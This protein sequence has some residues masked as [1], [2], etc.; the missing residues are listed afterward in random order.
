M[1]NAT[2]PRGGSDEPADAPFR[3]FQSSDQTIWLLNNLA[4][5]LWLRHGVY[6]FERRVPQNAKPVMTT[7][8]PTTNPP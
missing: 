7:T 3:F 8:M 5:Q 4:S 1:M 6:E 2:S